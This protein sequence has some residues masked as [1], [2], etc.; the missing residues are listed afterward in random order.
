MK[1]IQDFLDSN[2][3][4]V[5]KPS[6]YIGG[7]RGS[8]V[9]DKRSVSL[10][11]A[12]CFPDIYE[13]GM[14]HLGIKIL[15]DLLNAQDYIW[16]ERVF[17]PW[18]DFEQRL[19]AENIPL[20][21]LESLDPLCE[22]D[23]I[24][25]TLQY[26]MSYT[27]LLSMLSLGGIPLLSEQ[28]EGLANLVICGGPCVCNPEPMADFVDIFVVGEGEEVTLELTELYREAKEKNLS[29]SEFLRGAAKIQGVYV[30]S[31]YNVQYNQDGT[32]AGITVQDGLPAKITKRYIKDLDKAWF[33]KT[34]IVP[35]L[36]VIH[37]RAIIEMTRGCIRGCRFCQAG[38]IYRPY[39]E[40][41]PQT[42]CDQ[43]KSL[44][45]TTGYEEISLSSL[46]ASDYSGINQLLS[47]LLDYTEKNK[48]NLS[49]PSL[50][51]DNFPPELLEKISR[52]RKSGLTFAPEAGTAR[53]RDIIKK[54]I[55][56]EEIITSCRTAFDGGQS[57]VK[58]YF[59]LSLPGETM[60]DIEAIPKLAK[61]IAGLS[62]K[63]VNIT[64]SVSV[65]VPKPHTPFEREAQDSLET[66]I[67]KQTLLTNSYKSGKV[68]IN[69]HDPRQSIIE[70]VLARGDRRLGQ[71]IA[72]VFHAG[73]RLE[74]WSEYF[75]Y[76]KWQNSLAKHNL[77]A[78][79]Y[80]SRKRP[81]EEILPWEH[82][83]MR[84]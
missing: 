38:Y 73:G 70:A 59:M 25:F 64:V 23:I 12:F 19:T 21:A 34:F 61:E 71:V 14:S 32:I 4:S 58:L 52:V 33:P 45:D 44:C 3:L 41:T 82:I 28:R 80:A 49:L 26:E 83:D 13:V 36:Q 31:L 68:K 17:A 6:R 39:R 42:L 18:E 79:F 9:K 27:T 2:L 35:N 8:I 53:M 46:S 30:P 40:K 81:Q 54:K 76:D 29:K 16:C 51:I 5:Q 55:T 43:A 78:S 62:Q 69:Y 7:E 22:F 63:R 37:D 57:G 1:N 74:S 67:E 10:R 65:F 15:Y 75:S 72:D 66:L 11:F 77:D 24:G 47:D 50:R 48:I 84:G 20:Y 60:E 56:E